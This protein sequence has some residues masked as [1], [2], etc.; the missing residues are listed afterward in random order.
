MTKVEVLE[1][2]V[3]DMKN[4]AKEF[5]GCSFDGKT[6]AEYFGN[7]AAAIASLA[8]IMKSIINDSR[9]RS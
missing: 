8:D 9:E 2:I 4:A 1:M 7:Q 5:D 6:V 3:E